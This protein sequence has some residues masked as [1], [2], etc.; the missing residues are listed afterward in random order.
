MFN[1][2]II[3][4]AHCTVSVEE[5]R[6]RPW[7]ERLF[8]WPW[9]PWIETKIV[10]VQQPDPNVYMLNGY[11]VCHPTIAQRIKDNLWQTNKESEE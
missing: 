5:I 6:C 3:E 11:M 7:K 8:G 1:I 2:R 10:T 4:E 9:R